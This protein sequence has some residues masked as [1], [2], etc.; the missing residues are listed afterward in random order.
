MAAR[1]KELFGKADT[2]GSGGLDKTEFANLLSKGQGDA[3]SSINTDDAFTKFDSNGDGIVSQD[4]MDSGMKSMHEQ[5]KSSM[6][7]MRFGAEEG[8]GMGAM[9]PPPSGESKSDSSS[10]DTKNI[11]S[12]LDT[13]GD[14]TINEEEL[15]S[16][17]SSS[18]I[19]QM[20]SAYMKQMS[21]SYSTSSDSLLSTLTA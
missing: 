16:G 5:M 15:T 10:S 20:I 19:Q 1:K 7:K 14:G 2:D 12:S 18:K 8:Q 4:E 9:P 17:L 3:S 6:N 11:M 13:N 21:S